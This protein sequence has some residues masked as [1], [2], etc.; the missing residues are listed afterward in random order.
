[1][2]ELTP[3]EPPFEVITRVPKVRRLEVLRAERITPHMVRVT[4]GGEDLADYETQGPDD[5]FRIFFP[6]PGQDRPLL[7][8]LGEGGFVWPEEAQR[9]QNR[10]YT[11]RRFDPATR[12]LQVDFVVHGDGPGSVWADNAAPGHLAGSVGPRRSRVMSPQVTEYLLFGD[13][14]ALPSIGRRLEELPA[15]VNVR[16]FV[17]VADASE[18]QQIESRA[19]VDLTWLHRNGAEPGASNLLEH[20]ARSI[21]TL[22]EGTFAW[23]SGEAGSIR[24]VRRH[25]LNDLG[26]PPAWLRFTGYWKRTIPNWD[27]HEPIPE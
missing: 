4:F 13:E 21:T 6:L 7:P 1:V 12:E 14:S 9:P 26:V 20:A 11:P 18:E 15:G 22:P 8:T 24:M 25:L 2:S 27:H 17:E 23:V 5:D 19:N 3:T 16:A 10:E